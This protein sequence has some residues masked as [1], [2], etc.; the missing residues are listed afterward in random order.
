MATIHTWGITI[1][2]MVGDILDM[3]MDSDMDMA[4][5]I[6]CTADLHMATDIT[7]L[8]THLTMEIA[9]GTTTMKNL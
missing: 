7:T 1:L 3:G 4:P 8:I 9:V 6:I 2:I 5:L